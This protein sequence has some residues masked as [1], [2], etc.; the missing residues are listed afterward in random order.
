MPMIVLVFWNVDLVSLDLV[1]GNADLVFG[2]HLYAHTWPEMSRKLESPTPPLQESFYADR[3][4]HF[5]QFVF[6]RKNMNF[7]Y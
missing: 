2:K 6:F 5:V 1:F 3:D 4:N 7:L